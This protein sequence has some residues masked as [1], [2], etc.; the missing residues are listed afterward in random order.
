[1]TEFLQPLMKDK[2]LILA[3]SIPAL[4]ADM[5]ACL[6]LVMHRPRVDEGGV[7]AIVDA[8]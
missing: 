4:T 7:P 1:M 6:S 8:L 5:R 2:S 3:E